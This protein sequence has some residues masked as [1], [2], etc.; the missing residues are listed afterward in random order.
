MREYL[1][2][3]LDRI[4]QYSVIKT[5]RFALY[6]NAVV[7]VNNLV[8]KPICYTE[9]GLPDGYVTNLPEPT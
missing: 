8:D 5:G 6:F 1:R 3:Q 2:D 9:D 4:N 7:V